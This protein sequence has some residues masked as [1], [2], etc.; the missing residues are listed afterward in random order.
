MLL[1]P[2]G[3]IRNKQACSGV[4]AGAQSS[5]LRETWPRNALATRSDFGKS[6]NAI[7]SHARFASNHDSTCVPGTLCGMPL[8]DGK[9]CAGAGLWRPGLT[10]NLALQNRD[11]KGDTASLFHREKILV[12]HMF[13]PIGY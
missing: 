10:S 13:A 9:A 12:T 11:T 1:S 6:E 8:P 7:A 2:F 4:S 5:H 3:M